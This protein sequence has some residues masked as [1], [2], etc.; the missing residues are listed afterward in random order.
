M[1]SSLCCQKSLRAAERRDV[2]NQLMRAGLSQRRSC[3]LAQIGRS[4]WADA[5]RANDNDQI[6]TWLRDFAQKEKRAVYCS[7]RGPNN[8]SPG[9]AWN[10]SLPNFYDRKCFLDLKPIHPIAGLTGSPPA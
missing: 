4:C 7:F 2:V 5:K 10:R 3:A 8:E 6:V 9:F 1:R